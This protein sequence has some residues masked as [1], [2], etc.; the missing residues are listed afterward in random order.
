MSASKQSYR[1]TVWWSLAL[2]FIIELVTVVLRFGLQLDSTRDTASTIGRLTFG[3]R[4]HHGYCG[5]ALMLAACFL[6]S[7][8]PRLAR[9]GLII[10][11]AL[12]LSDLIH[13]FLV[14]W[15]LT[16]SPHFDLTYPPR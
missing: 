4:I 6:I 5:L 9:W 2:T 1:Y 11:L 8:F 13:H 3:I 16:G 10:G 15:P 14:L 7:R 12:V